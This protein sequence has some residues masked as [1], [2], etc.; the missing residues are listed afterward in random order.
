MKELKGNRSRKKNTAEH[1]GTETGES[2][3]LS[4]VRYRRLAQYHRNPYQHTIQ[5]KTNLVSVAIKKY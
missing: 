5:C 1:R 4:P 2:F 3:W